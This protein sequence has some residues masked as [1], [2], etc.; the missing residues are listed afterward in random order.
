MYLGWPGYD[1]AYSH[2]HQYML[3]PHLLVAPVGSP[4]DPATKEVW[5]PPGRWTDIFT[6]ARYSGPAV[7]TLQVPLDRMPVFA[8]AGAI[9]PRQDY[10]PEGDRLPP[11]RLIVDAYPGRRGAFTLYEDAGDGLAYERGCYAQTRISQRRRRASVVVT[12]GR[13]R[14]SYSGRP[15]RRAYELRVIGARRPRLARLG[16][17]RVAWHYLAA[18]RTV[19]VTTPR[20][21]TGRSARL[22]LRY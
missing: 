19:I 22:V 5:F 14:G 13:A 11:T 17:R 3:G 12:I 9:V 20:L 21:R 4:G 8:R 6:G 2:S 10:R 1:D 7:R 15:R 16:R 18:S